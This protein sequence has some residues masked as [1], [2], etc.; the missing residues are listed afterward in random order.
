MIYM[1]QSPLDG[2]MFFSDQVMCGISLV[3]D[4]VQDRLLRPEGLRY[5]RAR[6]AI[7]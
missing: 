2:T 4:R 3:L 7:L 1:Y 6:T 5:L